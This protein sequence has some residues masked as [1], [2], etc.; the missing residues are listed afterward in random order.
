MARRTRHALHS[1]K[2][3]QDASGQQDRK[4]RKRKEQGGGSRLCQ[5]TLQSSLR[6]VAQHA[7]DFSVRLKKIQT[8]GLW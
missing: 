8:P 3:G 6:P 4:P 2:V 5:E 7:K 1:P